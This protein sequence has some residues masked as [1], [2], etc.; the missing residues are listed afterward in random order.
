MQWIKKNIT[1][2]LVVT[3]LTVGAGAVATITTLKVHAQDTKQHITREVLDEDFVP[4]TELDY[5]L[6]AQMKVLERIDDNVKEL[7]QEIK[8][9]D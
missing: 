6:D 1:L 7:K 9:L 2:A 4:R 8:E 5:R 3:L